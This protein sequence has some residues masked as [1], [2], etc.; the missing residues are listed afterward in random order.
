M[1][2]RRK[3]AAEYQAEN[4]KLTNENQQLKKQIE[5][6]S[7][8][9]RATAMRHKT[10]QAEVQRLTENETRLKRVI[11]YAVQRR[12]EA[13]FQQDVVTLATNLDLTDDVGADFLQTFGHPAV[14]VTPQQSLTITT[15]TGAEGTCPYSPF[16][17]FGKESTV[18]STGRLDDLPGFDI[19]SLPT[20]NDRS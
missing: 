12:Q 19:L 3:T 6:K 13:Q 14:P 1:R 5:K 20:F 7:K 4:K 8:E 17:F 16:G 10:L 15:A 2:A 9:E 11:A 18:R